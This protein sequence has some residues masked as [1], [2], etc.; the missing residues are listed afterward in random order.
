MSFQWISLTSNRP[1]FSQNF[2]Y[3]PDTFS[4][5][6]STFTIP[7][8]G[9]TSSLSFLEVSRGRVYGA[10]AAAAMYLMWLYRYPKVLHSHS[11]EATATRSWLLL[12]TRL[13]NEKPQKP[14][15]WHFVCVHKVKL[16]SYFYHNWFDFIFSD[17]L[18]AMW[19]HY[20]TTGNGS[21]TRRLKEQCSS[22]KGMSLRRK[23]NDF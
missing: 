23:I 17:L 2:N 19:L 22:M 8:C 11:N 13:E 14:I 5:C 18:H 20:N 7:F 12:M 10:A 6:A 9:F 3:F 21:N 15:Q 1:Q 4:L 16:F